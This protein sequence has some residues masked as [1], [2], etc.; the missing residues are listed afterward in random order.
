MIRQNLH[1]H[2]TWDDGVN[3]L[4][5]MALAASAAGLSS[6]GFSVHTPM[7]YNDGWDWTIAPERLT[8]YIAEVRRLKNEF[9]GRISIYC[10]A[11]WEMLSQVSLEAFEYVIGSIHHISYSGIDYSVDAAAG[12]TQRCLT[13]AFNGDADVAAEVYFAQYELLAKVAK[14]DI[15]GHFDLLTKFDETE[16]YYD[17]DSPRF[18]A[19]ALRAMD[20]LVAAEKIFEINT[21]A[22]ARGYRTTP[23]PSRA[24]L[25]ELQ[26]RGGRI[27][28]SA[29][30]H[31]A[32]HIAFWFA[33]AEKLALDCGFTQIWQFDG[34]AF[35]PV[36]I[37]GSA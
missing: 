15:V 6:L 2:S 8:D 33:E 16:H 28:I 34:R 26:R 25:K 37:G 19:A 23:Y 12:E 29:D 1:A 13:E 5:E 7:P 17:S 11:E 18:R 35:V 10:G 22:I 3:S 9:C 24:L 4:E 31:S 21:G 36:R 14:V 32:A 27:A 20:S 30:A